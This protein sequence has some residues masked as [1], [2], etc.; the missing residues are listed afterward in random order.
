ML[1]S[2]PARWSRES[3]KLPRREVVSSLMRGACHRC[4]SCGQGK[5]YRAFLKI[6]DHC[7]SC[8]EALHHH[9][10]DDAPP[11]FTIFIVGKVVVPTALLVEQT[12]APALWL[13]ATLW[14]VLAVILTLAAL[15][16][17]KGALVGYQWAL[18]MHGFDPRAGG[19]ES[20]DGVGFQSH[21]HD[22]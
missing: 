19:D 15:P 9:R 3:G 7:P 4:P 22:P 13:Q 5:I 18:Y 14:T 12:L 8:A 10:A 1:Q 2:S 21:R 16:A 6:A 20:W 11:Y 17:V